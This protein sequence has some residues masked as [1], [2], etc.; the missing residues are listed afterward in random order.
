M[1]KPRTCMYSIVVIY[2]HWELVAYCYLLSASW[3]TIACATL[4]LALS[5][6]L[7]AERLRQCPT[8]G[9]AIRVL[10][11]GLL[12]NTLL[13]LGVFSLLFL[14]TELHPSRSI[15]PS[16]WEYILFDAREAISVFFTLGGLRIGLAYVGS[17]ITVR[18]IEK[19]RIRCQDE[20]KCQDNSSG[21]PRP[22]AGCDGAANGDGKPLDRPDR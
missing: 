4:P 22:D 8:H 6:H 10:M 5:N 11:V 18:I 16:V 17:A 1:T 19:G 21:P 15:G 9:Q 2:L 3:L 7:T 20:I 12:C 14:L 13:L